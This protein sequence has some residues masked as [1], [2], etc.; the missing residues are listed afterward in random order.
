MFYFL[1]CNKIEQSLYNY[2][3]Y[4]WKKN[5]KTYKL[6]RLKHSYALKIHVIFEQTDIGFHRKVNS[7]QIGKIHQ[8]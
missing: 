5:L 6:T 7:T 4:F 8:M 2:N 1:L 3:F